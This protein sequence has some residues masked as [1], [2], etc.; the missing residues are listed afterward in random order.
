[1]A[2]MYTRFVVGTALKRLDALIEGKR[3]AHIVCVKGV[4]GRL[5]NC[6]SNC[7]DNGRPISG[8][9]LQLICNCAYVDS[10][11]EGNSHDLDGK[12]N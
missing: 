12:W 9:V 7:S 2:L 4:K 1:M 6:L 10:N 11:A 8:G 5:R 3:N